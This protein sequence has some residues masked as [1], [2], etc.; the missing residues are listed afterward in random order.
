MVLWNSYPDRVCAF[1]CVR[2]YVG[3]WMYVCACACVFVCVCD[4][5]YAHVPVGVHT[6][7]CACVNCKCVCN[8]SGQ[9]LLRINYLHPPSPQSHLISMVGQNYTEIGR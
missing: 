4:R 7:A 9:A 1:V 2:V 8:T 6:C 3:V 5:V